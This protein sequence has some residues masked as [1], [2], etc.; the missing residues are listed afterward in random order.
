MKENLEF[1]QD[2]AYLI[3]DVFNRRYY[4][5]INCDEGYVLVFPNKCYYFADARYFYAL[6]Q[7][8]KDIFLIITHRFCFVNIFS[9]GQFPTLN[10]DGNAQIFHL[11]IRYCRLI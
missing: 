4:S 9:A 3:T 11:Q 2:S 5:G 1:L 7:K 6:K 10:D 8:V